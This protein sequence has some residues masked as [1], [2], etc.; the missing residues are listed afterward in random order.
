MNLQTLISNPAFLQGFVVMVVIVA[1]LVSYVLHNKGKMIT[2]VQGLMLQAQKAADTLVL[3][4]GPAMFNF[5]V[6]QAYPML[7]AIFRLCFSFD[8]FKKYAQKL[9]DLGV[10]YFEKG[11][12]Q[13]PLNV[14]VKPVEPPAAPPSSNAKSND[15][16]AKE[17]QTTSVS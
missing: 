1:G 5:V 4:D 6:A 16:P 15:N 9:Y 14:Q 12:T 3:K 10:L 11:I 2:I 8:T 7:P 13:S 17:V